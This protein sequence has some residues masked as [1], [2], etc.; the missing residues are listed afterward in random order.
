[1]NNK[2]IIFFQP[3]NDYENNAYQKKDFYYHAG[4]KFLVF[5][6][7]D[8]IFFSKKPVQDLIVLDNDSA[9]VNHIKKNMR[10]FPYPGRRILCFFSFDDLNNFEYK[11]AYSEK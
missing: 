8:T 9:F 6:L 2:Q 5:H 7:A 11:P 3:D 4:K 10:G 1:M